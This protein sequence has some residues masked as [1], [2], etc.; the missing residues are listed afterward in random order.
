MRKS[1]SLG[2]AGGDDGLLVCLLICD[3][4]WQAAGEAEATLPPVGQPKR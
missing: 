1:F 2:A 3:S 4:L